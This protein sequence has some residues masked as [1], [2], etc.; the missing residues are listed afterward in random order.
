MQLQPQQTNRASTNLATES[1]SLPRI[2]LNHADSWYEQFEHN[3]L[4]EGLSPR[5]TDSAREIVRAID[6]AITAYFA[7]KDNPHAHSAELQSIGAKLGLTDLRPGAILGQFAHAKAPGDFVTL[8]DHFLDVHLQRALQSV[9]NAPIVSE[10]SNCDRDLFTNERCWVL[11]PLD[12]TLAYMFGDHKLSGPMITYLENG[13]PQFSVTMNMAGTR[14]GIAERGSG[15]RTINYSETINLMSASHPGLGAT[16]LCELERSRVIVNPQSDARHSHPLFQKLS[17]TLFR[18]GI[19]RVV[20]RR[21]PASQLA[22]Q[23]DY[24]HLAALIH[25]NSPEH[26]K[27]QIWD[28]LPMQ[29]WVEEAGGIFMGI[30]GNRYDPRNPMPIVAATDLRTA[31]QLIAIAQDRRASRPF[32]DG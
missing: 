29:L 12:G 14:L 32:V 5:T 23:L 19:V 7:A 24:H 11:D 3:E 26:L 6:S 31:S 15:A 2:R 10:E 1:F 17:E 20:E 13:L 25:D 8:M 16:N 28:V 4:F 9:I 18:G 21:L 22:L 27:Q 30:D